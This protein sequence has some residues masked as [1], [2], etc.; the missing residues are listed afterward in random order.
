MFVLHAYTHTPARMSSVEAFIREVLPGAEVRVPPLPFQLFSFASLNAVARE[1]LAAMD[2][3]VRR[4]EESSAPYEEIILVGYSAGSLLARK[5][6]ILIQG[7]TKDAPFEDSEVEFEEPARPWAN[8]VSRIILLAGM[9][10][11]WAFSSHMKWKT[12]AKF[13]A[14]A[15]LGHFLRFVTGKELMIFQTRRGAPFLTQL[16]LQWMAMERRVPSGRKPAMVVQLLGSID[17]IV[18][19]EDNIDL[20][21]GRNFVYLDVPYSGHTSIIDLDENK[22]GNGYGQGRKEVLRVALT[23]SE[24]SLR[25]ESLEPVDEVPVDALSGK[26]DKV[27]PHVI[28]VM[29]GI[30]DEGHWTRKIARAVQREGKRIPKVYSTETSTYGY[31]AM[32]PF[33]LSWTRR[34]KMEWLMDQYV[35]AKALYPDSPF[36]YVGHS[37]GTYLLAKALTSYR[38]CRFENVVFAGSVVR[39]DYDWLAAK[40]RG[41]VER[42]LNYVATG[43]GVVAAFPGSFEVFG[44]ELG[45]AG[46]N[47]FR[48]CT[49]EGKDGLYEI[50]AVSGGH[51]AAIKE[52]NWE[53][54]AHFIVHGKPAAETRVKVEEKRAWWCV[55]L[56]AA[57]PLPVVVLAV[58]LVTIALVICEQP[59]SSE[60][61]AAILALYFAC[62]GVILT[63]A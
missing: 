26:E 23:G 8:K 48:Q 51:G 21:T 3:E 7:E 53:A 57:A 24:E 38:A 39:R 1:V 42:L 12:L 47:G 58:L 11:G 59:A 2:E 19:P 13:G 62:L 50:R 18:S 40:Q 17:D 10:R 54:I 25:A 46:H 44:S 29:H 20:V 45:S 33:L 55:M 16:R 35:E 37:N 9:N 28:F 14:G 52:G 4:A 63:K 49:K 32:L 30:R 61:R 15:L 43:D 22:D 56:G 60:W 31:F 36:S 34:Q 6:Q 41:Q 5:L 27:P